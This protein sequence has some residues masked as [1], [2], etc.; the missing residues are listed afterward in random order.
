MHQACM[1]RPN[2]PSSARDLS[3]Y[4]QSRAAWRGGQ[5]GS[6]EP[7]AYRVPASVAATSE[8]EMDAD[9]IEPPTPR[10]GRAGP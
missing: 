6:G 8:L 1:L 4:R 9:I 2:D 7:W 5:G 10:D 3:V